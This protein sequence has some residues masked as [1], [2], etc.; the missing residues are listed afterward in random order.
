MTWAQRRRA[1]PRA[2]RRRV[3][4][5]DQ[6]LLEDVVVAV[7]AP[8]ARQRVVDRETAGQRPDLAAT[9]RRPRRAACAASARRPCASASSTWRS[10]RRPAPAPAG[11]RNQRDDVA[12]GD[13]VRG[14]HDH[15]R[16]VERRVEAQPSSTPWATASARC[17]RDQHA[18]RLEIVEVARAPV[19]LATPS[20][21]GID[22]PTAGC[23]AC[24][25]AI[26][27]VYPLRPRRRNRRAGGVIVASG[28]ALHCRAG[29]QAA[30]A[31]PRRGAPFRRPLRA[32]GS[33]G[34]R[35]R[36]GQPRRDA[37]P[38]G[39]RSPPRPRA[40]HPLDN[41]SPDIPFSPSINPYKGCEHGCIY[42]F[43]RPSHAYLGLSPGADFESR[44]VAKPDAAERARAAARSPT[45][46]AETSSP[47]APTPTLT[48]R[49]NDAIT[50]PAAFSR[51]SPSIRHPVSL[52]TKSALILRDL[53]LLAPTGRRAAW[54]T[55]Y[56]RSPRSTAPWPGAWSLGPRPHN[57]ACR[58]CALFAMPA[59]P[60]ACSLRR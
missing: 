56:L 25:S 3:A 1:R 53:D 51:C 20:T 41:D 17:A 38:L 49:S 24:L 4:L 12:A 32:R 21:P 40:R 23:S 44:L 57:A 19:T 42:C 55:F 5:A 37:P 7:R 26:R 36:L 33:P 50:S 28:P 29:C 48:S 43:A 30:P 6:E 35:R 15:V 9:A 52:V 18:G 39:T 16:P 46:A 47:S 8:R 59:F 11:P 2:P 54:S 10:R 58:R 14:G 13:V 60:S 22:A 34:H 27:A 45:I 31:R